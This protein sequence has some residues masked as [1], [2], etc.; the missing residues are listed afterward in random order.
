MD[1]VVD[2]VRASATVGEICDVFRSIYGE[3]KEP[4]II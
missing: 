2:C 3:Y 4:A 1:R